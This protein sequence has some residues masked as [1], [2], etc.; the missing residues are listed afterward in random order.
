MA[1]ENDVY[2]LLIL[3]SATLIIAGLYVY[4]VLNGVFSIRGLGNLQNVKCKSHYVKLR[5]RYST[6]S[7]YSTYSYYLPVFYIVL[8]SICTC[9]Q[10]FHMCTLKQILH[11][12]YIYF[13][14]MYVCSAVVED[15]QCYDTHLH[16][17]LDNKLNLSR[18]YVFFR[19]QWNTL[20]LLATV[21]FQIYIALLSNQSSCFVMLN[22]YSTYKSII[23][24]IMY[25]MKCER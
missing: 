24:K 11:I 3:Q 6:Y 21:Q 14:L 18:I 5:Y 9:Q 20:L 23:M 25:R 4:T 15:L 10:S 8:H 13:Y 16:H 7:T 19:I 1:F 17:S 22:R 12:Q 2:T